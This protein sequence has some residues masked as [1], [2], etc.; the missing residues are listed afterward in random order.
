MLLFAVQQFACTGAARHTGTRQLLHK[1]QPS[2]KPTTDT[3]WLLLVLL[4]LPPHAHS[5]ANA[6]AANSSE[7]PGRKGVSTSPVSQNTMVQRMAYVAVP[8]C[9]IIAD[10]CLSRC[11]MKLM[12]AAGRMRQ[13]WGVGGWEVDTRRLVNHAASTCTSPHAN[14]GTTSAAQQHQICCCH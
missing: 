2:A 11:K 13:I 5:P 7:S 4:L 1:V 3:S 14:T 9:W 8:C 6:P 10:R 12:A